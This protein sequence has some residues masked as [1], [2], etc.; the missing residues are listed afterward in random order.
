VTDGSLNLDGNS[1]GGASDYQFNFYRKFGDGNGDNAVDQSDYLSFRN[2]LT[3]PSFTFD[4][5]NDGT[6]DQVDYL[7]F[8]NRIGT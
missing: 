7:E 8:R 6:V 3:L 4:Y 5:N 2:A 1:D